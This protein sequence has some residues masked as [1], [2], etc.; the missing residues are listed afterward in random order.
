MAAT[1][2]RRLILATPVNASRSAKWAWLSRE[3]PGGWGTPPPAAGS[4]QLIPKMSRPL[5]PLG[6][7]RLP[8]SLVLFFFHE[9]LDS[10]LNN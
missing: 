10:Q 1:G 2:F 7:V 3:L 4:H 6:L 9:T 8:H 5:R